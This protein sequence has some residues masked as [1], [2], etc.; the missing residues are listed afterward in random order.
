MI[1][2]IN[3][4]ILAERTELLYKNGRASNLTVMFIAV[5]MLMILHGAIKSPMLLSWFAVIVSL[6]VIRFGMMV[7]RNYSKQSRTPKYWAKLYTF[8]TALI[9]LCW[10]WIAIIGYVDDIWLRMVV[11]MLVIGLTALSMPVLVSHPIA[12]YW[13]VMPSNLAIA[14]MLVTDGGRTQV[15][16][17]VGVVLYMLSVIR[18][19]LNFHQVLIDGL[20]HGFENENLVRELRVAKEDAEAGSRSK[21]DFLANMSHEIRTPMNAIIGMSKLALDTPLISRKQDFIEKVNYSARLLLG[22]IND[23]LDFSKIEAGKLDMERIDFN[24]KSVL[25]NFSNIIGLKS[26]EQGLEL[27][28]KVAPDVPGVLKGDPLRLGQILINLGN[29]AVKFTPQGAITISVKLDG[30]EEDRALLHFCVSDTG[31]GITEEQQQ[32]LFQ[33]FSQADNSISRQYGGTGLGL[34]ISK[35]LTQMMGGE[36][37][38]ESQVGEG[39]HFHF[40]VMM[41]KGDPDQ[42]QNAPTD[43]PERRE[44]LMGAKILLVE[45]SDLNQELAIELLTDNGLIIT[46]AWNGQEALK[47]LETETF[48][49]ILMDIQMP[50]MDGYEATRQIRKQS[51]FKELPIIAMTANVMAGDLEKSAEA[52]MNDHIGKPFDLDDLLNTLSKWITMEDASS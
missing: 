40:T 16:L 22:I 9:G 10:M 20:R 4:R 43:T 25:E 42:V 37:W 5:A 26:A 27:E 50:V 12:L 14:T 11:V 30:R 44:N 8:A 41:E 3:S 49:G 7:S 52:G 45:D 29:N 36:I 31:I 15:L 28:I 19:S 24:L 13:Y 47:I 38:V 46:S 35:K 6:T 17:A 33:S 39:S 51:R 48:D 18:T 21:S 2:D 34:A 23:I 1:D 32:T